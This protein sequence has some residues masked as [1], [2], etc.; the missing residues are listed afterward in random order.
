MWNLPEY[1]RASCQWAG[2]LLLQAFESLE[3]CQMFE[4]LERRP[5]FELLK[6]RPV[7]ELLKGKWAFGPAER[8]Q[9]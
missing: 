9:A 1:F 7:F 8:S 4:L 6:R 5:V 2:C 3:A